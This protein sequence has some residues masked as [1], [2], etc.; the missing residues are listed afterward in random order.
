MVEAVLLCRGL[1]SVVPCS[2]TLPRI[3]SPRCQRIRQCGDD[4]RWHLGDLLHVHC[5][6]CTL[7][8]FH[9][10]VLAAA[11]HQA[12]A[13]LCLHTLHAFSPLQQMVKIEAA[14]PLK[15][16][17]VSV[18]Q[19]TPGLPRWM[20]GT[21]GPWCIV[22]QLQSALLPRPEPHPLATLDCVQWPS[23]WRAAPLIAP[24]GS[25]CIARASGAPVRPG[26]GRGAARA[27]PPAALRIPLGS[28][29]RE[30]RSPYFRCLP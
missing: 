3:F 25:R 14:V 15:S 20:A 8:R 19:G 17:L 7:L 28:W 30:D 5:E 16:A 12:R 10:L 4:G 6:R 13:S 22:M 26:R 29:A 1:G 11:L 9:W 27:R 24:A 18:P 2:L 21:V 23:A